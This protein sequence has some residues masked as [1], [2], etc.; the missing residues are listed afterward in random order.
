MSDKEHGPKRY[1]SDSQLAEVKGDM[2][3][4]KTIRMIRQER[5]LPRRVRPVQELI[6]VY[7][8]DVIGTIMNKLQRK[9][10]SRTIAEIVNTMI[11]RIDTPAEADE[12]IAA[13]E[14]GLLRIEM[15]KQQ[16]EAG[17]A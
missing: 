3:S 5:N 14:D 7:G 2:E 15:R 11:M 6:A 8:R 12:V 16:I 1:L 10:R 4:G 13:L 9:N 17:H